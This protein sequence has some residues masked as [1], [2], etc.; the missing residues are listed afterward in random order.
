MKKILII[1][2]ALVLFLLISSTYGLIDKYRKENCIIKGNINND[3]RIYHLPGDQYYD[4]TI[5][6]NNDGEMWLCS[7]EEAIH[8]GFRHSN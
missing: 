8:Y 3:E 6:G 5:I 2:P 1:L 4:E 7:P